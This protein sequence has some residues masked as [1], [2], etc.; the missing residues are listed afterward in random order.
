MKDIKVLHQ[1]YLL[2]TTA[3]RGK[4]FIRGDGYYLYDE[5]DLPYIDLMTN[6]GVSI[7]GYNHPNI[8][9]ALSDQL[10]TLP[11]LHSSFSNDIRAEAAISLVKKCGGRLTNVYF[12][13]SGAEAIEAALKFA[14]FATGK[15]K[16]IS[17]EGAYHGKTFGSLAVT[18]SHKYKIGL[19][20]NLWQTEFV[21]YGDI[22]A[23]STALT[24]DIAAVI[25]EPIQGET[26]IVMPPVG[27]LK[28]VEDLCRQNGILLIVDEIQ[29]GV[30]RT[31]TFLYSQSEN[32]EPDIV[33][34]GK[35][36]AGGIPVGATL[37]GA[38]IVSKVPKLSQTSTFGGN[39][40][41]CRGVLEV[42]ALLDDQTLA[43]ITEL[44]NE[45]RNGL[46]SLKSKIIKEVR[47]KGLMI[48]LEVTGD[49]GELLKRIQETQILACPAGDNVI[50]FLP[51]YIINKKLIKEVVT[52]LHKV[53]T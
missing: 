52:K 34:L 39:P 10:K 36:L 28:A 25:L 38:E 30:G 3:F 33:C 53:F 21:T 42:I 15:S 26:G 31:G 44:G 2:N 20:K 6:Y 48:G 4:S 19:E 35:G 27:Y 13:N 8:T 1:K 41:A 7:F 29:T 50:R 18:A 12:S 40:L 5:A 22:D 43:E 51:P 37:V 9:S 24:S 23:L 16:F 14:I 17:M 32:V 47:G 46:N 11:T 49:R 45:F